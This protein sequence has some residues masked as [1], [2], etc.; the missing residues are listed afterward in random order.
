[1][2][3]EVGIFHLRTALS[4]FFGRSGTSS[5][6]IK[7]SKSGFMMCSRALNLR[8]RLPL[9]IV[10]E[11]VFFFA[12]TGNFLRREESQG[13]ALSWRK[14][15]PFRSDENEEERKRR[16]AGGRRTDGRGEPAGNFD[17]PR[18]SQKPLREAAAH[19]ARG[20]SHSGGVSFV[21]RS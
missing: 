7:F 18:P 13:T 12:Y 3:R 2:T 4:S 17:Y 16:W 9:K 10:S 20:V 5:A 14:T 15:S 6:L 8:G 11:D 19:G 1:M 21:M